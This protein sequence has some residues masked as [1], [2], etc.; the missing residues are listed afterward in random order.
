MPSPLPR[1]SLSA[2]CDPRRLQAARVHRRIALLVL[3]VV[4]LPLAA[5]ARASRTMLVGRVSDSL[6][7]VGPLAGATIFS[8]G[9]ATTFSDTAGRFR[10][11]P[12]A[13]GRHVVAF[14]HPWLDS[15]GVFSVP[16]EVE[17][18]D[19][20]SIQ[21][22]LA[23]PS[24]DVLYRALCDSLTEDPAGIVTGRVLYAETGEP[25]SRGDV[26]A[27]WTEWVITPRREAVKWERTRRAPIRPDGSYRLCNVPTNVRLTL[28]VALGNRLG[29]EAEVSHGDRLIVL[30]NL[31]ISLAARAIPLSP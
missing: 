6:Q 14:S 21:V 25:A 15:I 7:Y 9:G 5:Q 24:R 17:V 8:V 11:G 26:L 16:R 29:L 1:R 28:Q 31:S 27:Y 22:E 19:A 10:L 18:P 13:P 2:G 4:P 12:L 20:D 3:L 23:T 30:R